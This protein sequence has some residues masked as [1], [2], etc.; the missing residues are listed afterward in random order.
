M[1]FILHYRI[2]FSHELMHPISLILNNRYY[3]NDFLIALAVYLHSSQWHKSLQ[4]VCGLF[5][6]A[7]ILYILSFTSSIRRLWFGCV[8]VITIYLGSF[9]YFCFVDLFWSIPTL[10]LN[11]SLHLITLAISFIGAASIWYYGSERGDK[12]EVCLFK[13]FLDFFFF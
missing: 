12:Q 13:Q 8:M 4:T 7:H 9:L 5:T 6:I 10:V 11:L 3:M 1:H 2:T